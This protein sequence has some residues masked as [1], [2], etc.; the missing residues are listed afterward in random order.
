MVLSG[1]S[2]LEMI[3]QLHI[4]LTCSTS[5]LQ[6]SSYGKRTIPGGSPFHDPTALLE[7][8][9]GVE[10]AFFHTCLLLLGPILPLVSQSG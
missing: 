5:C 1:P 9:G 6:T 4:S 2:T 3:G 8:P 10:L 7:H